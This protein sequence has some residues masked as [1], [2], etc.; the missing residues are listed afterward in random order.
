MESPAIPQFKYSVLTMGT[1][2]GVHKGHQALFRKVI[3]RARQNNGES[4][5]ISYNNHPREILNSPD[6]VRQLVHQTNLLPYILTEKEKKEQLIREIGIDYLFFLDFDYRM[7]LM[8]ASDF[9]KDIIIDKFKAKEIILG[10]DCH[11]GH[12]R[13]GDYHFL[14][15]YQEHYN[16]ISMFIQPVKINDNIVSSS[17]IRSMIRLGN[18]EEARIYIGRDYSLQ[19]TV[20][21]GK[22]IGRKI[23]FPTVNI[24]PDE[25]L[26]LLPADGVYLSKA[27]WNGNNYYCLTNIGVSPTL[28]NCRQSTI[29]CYLLNFSE[30]LYGE[31]ISIEFMKRIRDEKKFDRESDLI[32]AIEK[33][34]EFANKY[35]KACSLR[36]TEVGN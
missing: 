33:D 30:E 27:K 24:Q 12:S 2:D 18:I 34:R 31:K 7:S 10:Y 23:G 11:F 19:G 5:V 3:A 1:F 29:E 25:K 14:K 16:Y 4:V 22:K 9:L 36:R 20:V 32:A 35:L 15:R 8:N 17:R 26:K 21:S 28:K 6:G 13:S